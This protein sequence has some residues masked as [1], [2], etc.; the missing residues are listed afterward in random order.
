MDKM[1]ILASTNARLGVV[2]NM[3]FAYDDEGKAHRSN[4]KAVYVC[5]AYDGVSGRVLLS[6]EGDSETESVE[7]TLL[8]LAD[9]RG[10][11]L[12]KPSQTSEMERRIQEQADTIASLQR[13]ISELAIRSATA[14]VAELPAQPAD[15]ET[16]I[17][18][19]KP[20]KRPGS[21]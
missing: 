13:Q 3:K 20:I 15:P 9:D 17:P 2:S 14:P 5:T 11:P 6:E 7:K 10:V 8:A 1:H 18:A 19:E 21:R 16:A 12:D 4:H